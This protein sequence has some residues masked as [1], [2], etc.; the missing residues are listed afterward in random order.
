MKFI[1]ITKFLIFVVFISNFLFSHCSE[2]SNNNSNQ[3]LSKEN[4]KLNGGI[5]LT[6]NMEKHR[7]TRLNSEI[8]SHSSNLIRASNKKNVISNQ[9]NPSSQDGVSAALLQKNQAPKRDSPVEPPKSGTI[10]HKGWVKYFKFT[11]QNVNKV[12]PKEFIKNPAFYEQMKYFPKED[13]TAKNSDGVYEY[14][15]GENFFYLSIFPGYFIFNQSK[16]VKNCFNFI[17]NF[18]INKINF[19]S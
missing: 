18:Y 12:T 4:S 11:N 8:N 15:R 1:K 16:K 2:N 6:E 3:I 17:I 7:K 13:F 10:M 9:D 5:Y 19:R 14:I